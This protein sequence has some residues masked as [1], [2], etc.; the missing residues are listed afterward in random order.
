MKRIMAAGLVVAG[1][2]GAAAVAGNRTAGPHGGRVIEAG[3]ATYE[4][5]LDAQHRAHV[6]LLDR[7]LAPVAMGRQQ[8]TLRV[9]P[10]EGTRKIPLARTSAPA[11]K[12]GKAVI[13]W[14]STESLPEPE[15]YQ[16]T[17]SV[18]GQGKPVNVRFVLI[19][20]ACRGCKLPEYACICDH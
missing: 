19:E 5:Y 8:A 9:A 16:V 6:F 1:L 20:Q 4:F 18:R 10:N 13:H 11:K 15:G 17:L 14:A 2:L 12:G 3:G 7:S